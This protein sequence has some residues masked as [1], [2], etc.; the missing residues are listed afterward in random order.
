MIMGV[1]GVLYLVPSF[2][3]VL[4]Q[5]PNLQTIFIV[6]LLLGWTVIGWIVAMMWALKGLEREKSPRWGKSNRK[7]CPS[8]GHS[9]RK[10]ARRCRYCGYTLETRR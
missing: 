9:L 2:T 1:V 8:C 6:N 4:R 3:A 7:P 10:S 5:R